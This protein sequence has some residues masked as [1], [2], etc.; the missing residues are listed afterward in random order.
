ML[1]KEYSVMDGAGNELKAN[2]YTNACQIAAN[3]AR[4]NAQATFVI[5]RVQWIEDKELNAP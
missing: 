1:L 3:L 5:V 4:N 2:G